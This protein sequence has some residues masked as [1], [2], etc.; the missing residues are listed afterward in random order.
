VLWDAHQYP[1][2]GEYGVIIKQVVIFTVGSNIF[3]MHKSEIECHASF[4]RW[5]SYVTQLKFGA[6]RGTSVAE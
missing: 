1:T 2:R 6:A 3:Q 4:S 5:D